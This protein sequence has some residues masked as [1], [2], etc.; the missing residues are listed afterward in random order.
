M[1]L[2]KN[3]M[4]FYKTVLRNTNKWYTLIVNKLVIYREY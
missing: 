4:I 3:V 1:K 2:K